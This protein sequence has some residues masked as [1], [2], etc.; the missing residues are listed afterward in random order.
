MS[1]GTH[2][3][4]VIL[5]PIHG[6]QANGVD[7]EFGESDQISFPKGAVV[8]GKKVNVVGNEGAV[9]GAGVVVDANDRV[10]SA[11]GAVEELVSVDSGGSKG[12]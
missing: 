11:R 9:V 7:A 1:Q 4:I 6:K 8:F 2:K 3:G 5:T 10:V 12:G